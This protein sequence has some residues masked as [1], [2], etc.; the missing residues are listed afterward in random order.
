MAKKPCVSTVFCGRGDKR[1]GPVEVK[2]LN[3]G[4]KYES[5]QNKNNT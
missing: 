1:S 4:V 2:F 5:S 3:T